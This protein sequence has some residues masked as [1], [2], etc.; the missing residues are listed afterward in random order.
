M[1]PDGISPI[2]TYLQQW[3]PDF[4]YRREDDLFFG[5]LQADFPQADLLT[6]LKAFHAWCLDRQGS[7]PI[8]YRLTLR[9]WLANSGRKRK[10]T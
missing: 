5:A 3:F 1:N 10:D 7:K 6:Q 8:N 4:G 2:R 9:K